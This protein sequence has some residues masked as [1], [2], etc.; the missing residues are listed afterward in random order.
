MSLVTGEWTPVSESPVSH[1]QRPAGHQRVT[2]RTHCGMWPSANV[3]AGAAHQSGMLA[4][5]STPSNESCTCAATVPT[6]GTFTAADATGRGARRG[7]V[8]RSHASHASH[9][10]H[11]SLPLAPLRSRLSAHAPPHPHSRLSAHDS[12]GCATPRCP[13]WTSSRRS[14]WHPRRAPG[15]RCPRAGR[16]GSCSWRPAVYAVSEPLTLPSY[17]IGRR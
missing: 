9:A 6:M 14:T 2:E 1:H 15:P 17:S 5:G 8:V 12:R 4:L 10:S 11:S 3:A 7:G 13:P 16:A